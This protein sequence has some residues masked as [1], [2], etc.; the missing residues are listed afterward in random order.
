MTLNPRG[1]GEVN[2]GAI[3]R[4][5]KEGLRIFYFKGQFM[6]RLILI[7]HGQ[8]DYHLEN[9]YCGFSNPSLNKNGI[10]QSEKLAAELK[11]AKVNKVYSSDLKRAYEAA[12][13]IFKGN[14]IEKTPEFCEMNFGIFEGLRYEEI[15]QKHAQAYKNWI[16]NPMKVRIEVRADELL[17]QF[18]KIDEISKSVINDWDTEYFSM[19]QILTS[20]EIYA[21]RQNREYIF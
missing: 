6:T 10:W 4:F 16:D 12:A 5:S 1:R 7:R 14:P 19:N 9:K 11:S 8:T 20:Q 15:V 17:E 2:Q 13:I 3:L 18:K 21:N